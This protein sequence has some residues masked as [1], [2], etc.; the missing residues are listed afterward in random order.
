MTNKEICSYNL[1]KELNQD[2]LF[3]KFG[4][5]IITVY[6]K[7]GSKFVYDKGLGLSRCTA[8]DEKV[9]G[10]L[11]TNDILLETL[12][13]YN[14]RLDIDKSAA[15]EIHYDIA[16]SNMNATM[17]LIYNSSLDLPVEEQLDTILI[18]SDMQFVSDSESS[19]NKMVMN[20]WKNR[21][22]Y[23]GLKWPEIVYWNVNQSKA[24]FLTSK[25]KNIENTSESSEAILKDIR[26]H[27][28]SSPEQTMMK[29]L[30]HYKYNS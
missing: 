18:I 5:R 6:C 24:T 8:Q 13:G 19:S 25:Y 3:R 20:F 1:I 9:C 2:K 7:D 12:Y 22:K 30:A 10:V 14:R 26:E 27:K 17:E 4:A 11:I 16:K 28:T 21:F 29:V 23:A 15:S